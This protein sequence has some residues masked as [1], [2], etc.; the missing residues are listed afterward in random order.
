MKILRRIGVRWVNDGNGNGGM[1]PSMNVLGMC[2]IKKVSDG[3]WI[4][5]YSRKAPR[6]Q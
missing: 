1:P 4:E 2:M 3:I 5:W 6:R